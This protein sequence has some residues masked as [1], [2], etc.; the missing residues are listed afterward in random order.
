MRF[1][2]LNSALKAIGQHLVE[3]YKAQLR[4]DKTDA[5]HKT[6]NSLKSEVNSQTISILAN[7][8]LKYI[9]EGR[10]PG[11]PPPV[12][13]ILEWAKAKGIRPNSKTGF[14]PVQG[15]KGMRRMAYFISESIGAKGTIK[16]YGGNGSGSGILEFV[17]KNNEGKILEDVLSAYSLDVEEEL[18]KTIKK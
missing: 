9:D 2:R 14:R 13:A 6:L 3:R 7:K 18:A 4:I 8:E 1:I 12:S 15:E 10:K 16:R 17:Y 11:A 5:T